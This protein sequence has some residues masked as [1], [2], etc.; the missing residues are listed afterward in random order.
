MARYST[1]H[2]AMAHH[3]PTQE[4]SGK[5]LWNSSPL[6]SQVSPSYLVIHRSVHGSITSG[7]QGNEKW[8]SG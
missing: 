2:D 7:T 1:L 5:N 4:A 6:A 3:R 8:T